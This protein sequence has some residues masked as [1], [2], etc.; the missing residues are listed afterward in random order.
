MIEI[1]VPIK[2]KPSPRPRFDRN[3]RHIYNESWYLPYKDTIAF[4]ARNQAPAYK[5]NDTCFVDILFSKNCTPE[6]H[7][8][9]DIDNLIKGVLDALNGIIWKDDRQVLGVTARKIQS[10]AEEIV[11]KITYPIDFSAVN[12]V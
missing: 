5:T 1:R 2:P 3:S 4:Y 11:I 6:S 7:L 8:Y 10:E 12:M 9:G